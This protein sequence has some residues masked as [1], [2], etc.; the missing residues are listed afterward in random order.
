MNE[1]IETERHTAGSPHDPTRRAAGPAAEPLVVLVVDDDDTV[2]WST[3]RVLRRAGYEVLEAAGAEEA[4]ICMHEHAARVSLVLSDV[5]M[6]K[7]NGHELARSIRGQWPAVDVVLISAYTPAAME[8]H[9]IDTA[10]FRQQ[11][12]PVVDLAGVV[13]ELIGSSPGI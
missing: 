12:K 4:L 6:P 5:I 9:G 8:R 3:A 7:Q 10:G 2:R 1:H 11:Q 13:A